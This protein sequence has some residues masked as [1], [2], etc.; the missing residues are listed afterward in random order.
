MTLIRRTPR[1]LTP[2]QDEM[3]RLFDEF[4]E[5]PTRIGTERWAGWMPPMDIEETPEAIRVRTELPGIGPDDVDINLTGQVLTIKGEKKQEAET[6]EKSFLRVERT[7]GTFTRSVT[8]PDDI[9]PEKIQATCEN[10]VLTVSVGKS[11][12]ARPR[13][14]T[15]QVKE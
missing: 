11:E 13:S 14:I 6:K 4:F 12:R 15:V 8:L 10:G 5:A 2:L 1:T 3:N 7:Y 9:D